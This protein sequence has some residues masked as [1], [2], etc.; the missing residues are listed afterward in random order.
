MADHS[1]LA[2]A[3]RIHQRQHILGMLVRA[4]RSLRFVAVAEAAQVRR[5]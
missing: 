5:Q 2:K 4:E 3:E 1:D